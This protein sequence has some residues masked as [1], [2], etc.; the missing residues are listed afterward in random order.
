[1]EDGDLNQAQVEPS[2]QFNIRP[3][4]ELKKITIFDLD[5]MK[6]MPVVFTMGYRYLPS[7]A[8]LTVNRTQ[9]VLQEP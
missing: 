4:E 8:Q 5:D 3:L 1:M 7:T 6:C 2:L 9:P